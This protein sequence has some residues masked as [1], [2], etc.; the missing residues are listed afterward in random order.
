MPDSKNKKTK[1]HNQKQVNSGLSPAVKG[2]IAIMLTLLV[3]IIVVMIFAKT[4]FIGHNNDSEPKKT[5][6][7]TSTEYIPPVTTKET[8]QKTEKTSETA[9]SDDEY[10]DPYIN[11]SGADGASSEITCTSAVYLHPQP[12][13]KSE[14]LATIPKGAKVKFFRNENGW[15]YVEYNGQKGYAWQTFFTAPQQ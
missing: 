5:G 11:D 3:V 6:A 10:E 9:D 14:N 1:N 4:L 12:T 2:T 13:S 8:T 7:I 15:Y